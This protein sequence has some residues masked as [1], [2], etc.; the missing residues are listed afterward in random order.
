MTE[1]Q[2]EL[3][4]ILYGPPGTGK[5]YATIEA[6]LKIVDPD[7]IKKTQGMSSEER[8][9]LKKRFDDF[10]KKGR[11]RF[12]TFHQSFSYED[13]VEGI[14]AT[15]NADTKQTEYRIE[16]GVFKALC[17][18]AARKANTGTGLN[19]PLPTL[20]Q[21]L[22]A[23][24]GRPLTEIRKNPKIWKISL[25]KATHNDVRNHCLI[26]GEAR[27]DWPRAGDLRVTLD[28]PNNYMN[29]SELGGRS[30]GMLE[31]FSKETEE[32]HVFKGDIFVCMRNLENFCAVGIVTGDYYYYLD[33]NISF[34]DGP[35]PQL[36]PVRWIYRGLNI[37]IK[38]LNNNRAFSQS[39]IYNLSFTW[40]NLRDYLIQQNAQ[41][42]DSAALTPP[43]QS[44][45]KEIIDK[46]FIHNI[47]DANNPYVTDIVE[48][49]VIHNVTDP[50]QPHF[51]EIDENSLL[52]CKPIPGPPSP[53][54]LHVMVIEG[55]DDGD[56]VYEI[57]PKT[58]NELPDNLKK[59]AA[60]NTPSVLVIDDTKQNEVDGITH[61]R[62]FELDRRVWNTLKA[63]W[64]GENRQPNNAP[65]HVPQ[66]EALTPPTQP[67]EPYVLIIDEINRGNVSRV[68]GEL[69]TLIEPDKR[70]GQSEALS[71]CLPYSKETFS[72]PDNVYL[73]GTMNT[74]DRSLAGLDIALRRRFSFVEMPP[75][76]ELLKGINVEGVNIGELLRVMNQRIELLLD[77]DHCLGHA[78][79]MPLIKMPSLP[80][81]G[82][83]FRNKIIPLLQEYF[84]EDWQRIHWVLNDHRKPKA[85]HQ[86][87]QQPAPQDKL[88]G[89]GVN[90]NEQNR[91]WTIN[92]AAFGKAE[93]YQGIIGVNGLPNGE[94]EAEPQ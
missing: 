10:V 15:V 16:D 66:A 54:Q 86:F 73:I 42:A 35:Y 22:P 14:R 44:H 33:P 52:V 20:D 5:T 1:T 74:A 11:I 23:F 64:Q 29:S 68:F 3:N 28:N 85:E 81:L 82:S 39:T 32:D 38:P 50:T 31:M 93:A 90:V 47:T 55:N 26:H 63:H 41:P 17:K 24:D 69:I 36:R 27:I 51:M 13:F 76:P 62:V 9:Q 65:A 92:D 46:K 67:R 21:P 88:F 58:W 87:V 78:Y 6:A 49:Q 43:E 59:A 71:V 12:V 79:F 4:Q 37:P 77:R 61:G 53:Q 94:N 45:V 70:D 75:R 34:K 57:D 18:V 8:R 19:Q 80:V 72:V 2:S 40:K 56:T 48:N 7:E 30:W 84:F 25:A 91:R 83:I 60:P 89:E